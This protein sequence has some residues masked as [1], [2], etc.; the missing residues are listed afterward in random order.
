MIN[1][2]CSLT[3]REL[4]FKINEEYQINVS[5]TTISKYIK[6][7]HFSVKRL[8]LIAQAST[9]PALEI[10]RRE[11]SSWFLQRHN[12]RRNLIFIDETGFQVVMRR[13][14]GRSLKGTRAC[15]VVP[16]IRSRNKTVIAAISEN[17][18]L[19]YNTP[20][21]SGNRDSFLDFITNLC[22]HL[23]SKFLKECILIMDNASFHRCSEIQQTIIRRG[24]ELKFLPP[25]SP[26][27]N[28][29]ECLFSQWK[30]I[31]RGQNPTNES[32]L[33]I[34]ISSFQAIIT[35]EQCLNYVQNVVNN[36]IRCLAGEDVNKIN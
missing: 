6:G 2:N 30:S 32:E 12:D 16:A 20:D 7:F 3:L 35:K 28:P 23:N 17:E 5:Q 31:V 19:L 24:H 9:K 34:A 25:Y 1:E 10:S 27:F 8:H 33:G 13:F 14:Y 21:C 18:L 22:D 11:Y 29:I 26:Y 4:K 15:N 36:C